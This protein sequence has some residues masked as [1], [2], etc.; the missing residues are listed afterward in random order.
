MEKKSVNAKYIHPFSTHTYSQ[1][2][3][4]FL[5]SRK[6]GFK[7]R[8]KNGI[9]ELVGRDVHRFTGKVFRFA[10]KIGH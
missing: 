6:K 9:Y 4:L 7:E 1:D 8:M 5:F 3:A 2:S 10:S